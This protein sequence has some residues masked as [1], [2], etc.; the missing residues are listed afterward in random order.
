MLDDNGN[1]HKH[2]NVN[3]QHGNIHGNGN[4][5]AYRK[6]IKLKGLATKNEMIMKMEYECK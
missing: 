6:T 5:N 1:E 3:N 4:K 2:E